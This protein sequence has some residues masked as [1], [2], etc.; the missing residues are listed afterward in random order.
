MTDKLQLYFQYPFVR[1]ALIVGI[2]FVLGD[3]SHKYPDEYPADQTPKCRQSEKNVPCRTFMKKEDTDKKADSQK[4][5][6]VFVYIRISQ[7]R[8]CKKFAKAGTLY[9]V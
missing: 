3:G 6:S 2:L 8:Y 4:C 9:T 1:Y 7:H 5:G